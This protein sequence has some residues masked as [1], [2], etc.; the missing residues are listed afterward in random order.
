[1]HEQL[2]QI[3][4][5][6]I[7]VSDEPVDLEAILAV[8]NGEASQENSNE[9]EEEAMEEAEKQQPGK[10]F[11]ASDVE[12]V[13]ETLLEKYADDSYPFEIKKIAKGY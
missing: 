5:S 3:V 6:I 9:E 8:L 7:F 2:P 12:P 11:Q 1:M 13:L 10:A 4:E